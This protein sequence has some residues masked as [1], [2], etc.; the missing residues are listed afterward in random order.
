MGTVVRPV[1]IG[2]TAHAALTASGGVAHVLARLSA[3]TYLTANEQ[4]IWLGAAGS[5]LHPRAILTETLFDPAIGVARDPDAGAV[6]IAPCQAP[7]WRPALPRLDRGALGDLAREWRALVAGA[8]DL[9]APDGFGALLVGAPLRFPLEGTEGA[10]HALARACADAE[11]PRATEAAL[12]L[13]G[14]GGGLTPSGDDFVG[15][16][17]FAR[18]WLASAGIVDPAAWRSVADV[19]VAAA[20]SRTHPISVALLGDLTWGAGWAPLHDLASALAASDRDAAV[21]AAG[22]LV[23]LGHT[24][25]WDLL[26]GVGAGLGLS[27]A[28][29][30]VH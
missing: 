20:A 5:A 18:A 15:G 3:S 24:S 10:A 30:L 29:P 11:P 1:A 22:R 25:G 27:W 6:R 21:R 23:R 19:V 14:R 2:V 17:L 13:L 7:P 4:I 8:A 26:A 12:E 9:G 16:A 28:A